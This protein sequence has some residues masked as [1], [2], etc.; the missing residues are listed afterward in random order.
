MH[1]VSGKCWYHL[2]LDPQQLMIVDLPKGRDAQQWKR[3]ISV[4]R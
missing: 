1:F 4:E 2:L 3:S